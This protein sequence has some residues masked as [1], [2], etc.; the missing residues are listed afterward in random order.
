MVTTNYAIE[1]SKGTFSL[2]EK[3]TRYTEAYHFY[4]HA[5]ATINT[6]GIVGIIDHVTEHS[7]KEEAYQAFETV[8]ARLRESGV[9]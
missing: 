8:K 2:I 5:W 1:F 4:G 9:E 3:S 6:F 7:L